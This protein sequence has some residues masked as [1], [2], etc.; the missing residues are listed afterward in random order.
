MT[1]EKNLSINKSEGILKIEF[2][3]SIIGKANE[4]IAAI[5]CKLLRRFG[6]TDSKVIYDC[7]KSKL[8]KKWSF[9]NLT[10]QDINF[11]NNLLIRH[12]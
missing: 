9:E 2:D 8:I 6:E 5:E 1:K 11:L 4:E 10:D 7:D 3:L 12:L